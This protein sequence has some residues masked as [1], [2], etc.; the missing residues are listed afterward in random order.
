MFSN[1]RDEFLKILAE[2]DLKIA[3]FELVFC[4]IAQYFF[5]TRKKIDENGAYERRDTLVLSCS[6]IPFPN[7][8]ESYPQLVCD[9]T[10]IHLQVNI[11]PTDIS[12]IHREQRSKKTRKR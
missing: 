9:L 10:K 5:K 7:N 12:V 2:N 4:S 11:S 8:V 6:C 3:T 1:F